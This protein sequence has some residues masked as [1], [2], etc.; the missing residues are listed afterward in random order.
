MIVFHIAYDP[1]TVYDCVVY[2]MNAQRI[3]LAYIFPAY[4]HNAQCIHRIYFQRIYIMP[5]VYIQRIYIMRCMD[6]VVVL[7]V[8]WTVYSVVPYSYVY[9]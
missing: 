3:Y 1:M 8:V 9:V 6:C 5:S 7:C 4:I 2:Y